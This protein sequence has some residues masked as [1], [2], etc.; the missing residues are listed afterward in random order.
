MRIVSERRNRNENREWLRTTCRRTAA[1]AS[2][3]AVGCAGTRAYISLFLC[4][5]YTLY[6][7]VHGSNAYGTPLFSLFLPCSSILFSLVLSFSL[8]FLIFVR[9]FAA[10]PS[11]HSFLFPL[12]STCVLRSFQLVSFFSPFKLRHRSIRIPFSIYLLA[13]TSFR[14]I[15]G[16]RT[17]IFLLIPYRSRIYN[18][19]E[20]EDLLV[21][22][23][24]TKAAWF[25]KPR[26]PSL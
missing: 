1:A 15:G 18:P 24:Y 16:W 25:R 6:I 7:D 8:S 23:A 21:F 11:S 17:V 26:T 20:R 3:S 13:N 9:T 4:W 12:L 2:A 5:Y 10:P 22:M 14:C 19:W